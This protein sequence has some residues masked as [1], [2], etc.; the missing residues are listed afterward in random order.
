MKKKDLFS[1]LISVLMLLSFPLSAFSF[2]VVDRAEMGLDE[3]LAVKDQ[4]VYAF[5]E[6]ILISSIAGAPVELSV[7][8]QNWIDMLYYH[9]ITRLE[10]ADIPYNY[11]VD[12]DGNVYQ[13]RSGWEG[14]I[15][16][17]EEPEG[18]ILIGYLSESG[19]LPIQAANSLRELVEDLSG[20]YGI[21]GES[22][23][24]V[25]LYLNEKVEGSLRK[26]KYV[27]SQGNLSRSVSSLV[28]SI[29]FSSTQNIE[30]SAE[31]VDIEHPSSVQANE[32]FE[33][34][35]QIKND[36]EIPWFT[37]NDY[38]YIVTSDLNDSIFAING[39]WDSFDTP[40]HLEGETVFP[41]DVVKVTFKMRAPL[42]PGKY[43]QDFGIKRTPDQ[44]IVGNSLFRVNVIVEQG[45][46]SLLRIL[47]TGTGSLNVREAPAVNGRLV[48]QVPVG[49][50]YVIIERGEGW[51]KIRYDG[52]NEGW[53]IARYA[54]EVR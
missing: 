16:E 10:F 47:D 35:V 24:V 33:V 51:Y 34:S 3:N 9:F 8:A 46:I 38:I 37:F 40:T 26:L 14:V 17:L 44:A 15:P 32:E 4:E 49:E 52:E 28:P 7:N 39:E 41:G 36:G 29:R 1:I 31:I 25:D 2:F 22:L 6:R 21:M 48:G 20:K 12:R 30:I 54:E 11:I 13:G 50:T 5:P 42:F 18:V 27:E 53:V 23:S 45:D 43:E 19:D